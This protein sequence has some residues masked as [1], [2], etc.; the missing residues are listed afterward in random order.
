MINL[1]APHS[2]LVQNVEKRVP[3]S[4]PVCNVLLKWD[5]SKIE[6]IP[7]EWNVVGQIRKDL[8][9]KAS[10]KTRQVSCENENEVREVIL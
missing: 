6:S 7:D 5:A 8:S 9:L 3:I 2:V 1:F 10:T 4:H